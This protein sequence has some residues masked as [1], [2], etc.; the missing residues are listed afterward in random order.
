MNRPYSIKAIADALRFIA[1]PAG[2][3]L[4]GAVQFMLIISLK[5]H[6]VETM[7]YL[8][9]EIFVDCGPNQSSKDHGIGKQ[10]W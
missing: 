9:V 10:G 7:F 1:S 2:R 3:F 6:S 8:L 4:P 5:N